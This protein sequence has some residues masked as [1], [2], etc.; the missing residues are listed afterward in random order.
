MN[1]SFSVPVGGLRP[2]ATIKASA[3]FLGYQAKSRLS[4]SLLLMGVLLLFSTAGSIAQ[5]STWLLDP[6]S[7]D[8][9]TNANWTTNVPF[10]TATFEVSN[11]TQVSVSQFLTGMNQVVFS[12]GASSFTISVLAHATLDFSGDGIINNSG[13]VQNFLSSRGDDG[14]Q[15]EFIF[16]SHASAGNF[17]TFTTR[18]R[19]GRPPVPAKLQCG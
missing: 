15:G 12:P 3:P 18:W 4:L 16:L 8:W 7:S 2:H 13:V 19:D 5:N 6:V 1:I 10:D 17:V 9:N 14:F 11:I